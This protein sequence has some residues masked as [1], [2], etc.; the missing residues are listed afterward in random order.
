MFMLPVT[1][2]YATYICKAPAPALGQEMSL[3]A[4]ALEAQDTESADNC[5]P[6]AIFQDNPP[7]VIMLQPQVMTMRPLGITVLQPVLPQCLHIFLWRGDVEDVVDHDED[8]VSFQSGESN[9]PYHFN[10]VPLPTS[11]HPIEVQ[12]TAPEYINHY[13][14]AKFKDI[15]VDATLHDA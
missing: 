1:S 13:Q 14:A 2:T 4:A 15:T 8:N 7:L 5:K 11:G 10:F 6:A 9:S 3:F 12:D